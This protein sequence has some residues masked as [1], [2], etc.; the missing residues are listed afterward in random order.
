M[1][2][3]F[4]RNLLYTLSRNHFLITTFI[5]PFH[6]SF[7]E[8][9]YPVIKYVGKKLFKWRLTYDPESE[10]DV[11]W[12]DGAVAPETLAKMH[13]CQKINHF[14]GMYSLARKNHLGRHLMRLKKAYPNNFKFFPSTWLLPTDYSDFKA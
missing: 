13:P 10:W 5:S 3:Y 7:L 8:T 11:C 14:P 2:A 6:S 4:S 1:K 9:K 12:T